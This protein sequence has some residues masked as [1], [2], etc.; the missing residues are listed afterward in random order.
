MQ[1]E[2]GDIS[3]AVR[4]GRICNLCFG[5][6]QVIKEI[7]FA[8]RDLN[9]KTI[10]YFIRNIEVMEGESGKRVEFQAE[11]K[12]GEFSFAWKG[13]IR[14]L[15]SNQIYFSFHGEAFDEFEKNRIGFCV[16]Y[17]SEFAGK[18]CIVEHTCGQ[19]EESS[20]PE[21]IS[22]FQPFKDIKK[23]TC[24]IE[25]KGQEVEVEFD[26]D[27]FEMEDQRN[28]TDN[29]FKVYCTPLEKKFPVKVKKGET[30]YQS[31]SVLCRGD[32]KENERKEESEVFRPRQD[33]Y[34]LE[35]AISQGVVFRSLLSEKQEQSFAD[36][37]LGHFRY[38]LHFPVDEKV[39]ESAVM[40]IARMNARVLLTVF[41]TADWKREAE[42]VKRAVMRKR[43]L[44]CGMIVHEENKNVISKKVLKAIRELLEGCGVFIGSGTDAFFT[45]LNRERLPKELLDFVVYSNNPQVHA[46]DDASILD[47]VEGQ[48]SNIKSC[49]K[50]YP[51]IPVWV[52]PVTLKMRWNPDAVKRSA[53]RA[54]E[55]DIRDQ[56]D[57][58]QCEKFAAV[59]YLKAMAMMLEEKA[60]GVTWFETVGELGI[61]GEDLYPVYHA[62]RLLKKRKNTKYCVQIAE[63]LVCIWMKGEK[64]ETGI[65][66]NLEP[67][68]KTVRLHGCPEKEYVELDEYSVILIDA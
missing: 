54:G 59:W 67:R 57:S 2:Y 49:R 44:Y 56:I 15:R 27:I 19:V 22:P 24:S 42:L 37:N 41:F 65:I 4:E 36:L 60:D 8:L 47:T 13:S 31:I 17:P 33:M 39:W 6:K 32:I 40:Q 28:W 58:R 14:I 26:G 23:I 62:M 63:D 66:G 35:N 45:Q 25:Q 1:I 52:T 43:E 64:G 12:Q 9:W 5:G 53:D 10:P 51:D 61:M 50:L 21:L 34:T 55:Y 3:F 29:S 38:E 11:H 30:F 20:F 7:Y 48:R 68:K 46:F 16:L 18:R